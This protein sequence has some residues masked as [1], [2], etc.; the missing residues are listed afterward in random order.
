MR[1]FRTGM[2]HG[3]FDLLH[4]GHL[5]HLQRAREHCNILMVSLVADAFVTKPGRPIYPQDERKRMLEALRIVDC[6]LLTKDET[7][8]DNIRY[9][10]PDV[11]IRGEE[12]MGQKR[13]EDDLI[14]SLGI[15]RVFTPSLPVTT[16]SIIERIRETALHRQ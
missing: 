12:Y 3:V 5:W 4:V 9:I 14:D 2:V 13:P 8:I 11:W 6:V 15:E 1:I 7:P 16:T 10:C